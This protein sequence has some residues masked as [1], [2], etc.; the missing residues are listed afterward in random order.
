VGRALLPLAKADSFQQ[1]G[2]PILRTGIK[3]YRS[4]TRRCSTF[5]LTHRNTYIAKQPRFS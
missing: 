2:I 1:V 5:H 3:I 4:I